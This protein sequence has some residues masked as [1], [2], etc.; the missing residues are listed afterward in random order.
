MLLNRGQLDGHRII[1]RK[2]LERMYTNH[3]DPALLPIGIGGMARP[4][5]GFGLGSSVL[6]DVT[7]GGGLGSVGEF[8]WSGAA[9][10]NFFVDPTEDLTAVFMA[11]YMTGPENP[12]QDFRNLVY[13][14]IID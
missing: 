9:K 6:M 13:Q 2:T 11:Q 5:R 8:S 3:L 10:T 12:D 7:K 4:G 1:G 14:A